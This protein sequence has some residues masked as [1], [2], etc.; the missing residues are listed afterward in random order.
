MNDE[1]RIL[2]TEIRD[3]LRLLRVEQTGKGDD[4]TPLLVTGASSLEYQRERRDLFD[5]L[6]AKRSDQP[7]GATQ[8]S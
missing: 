2:L 6:S 7:A 4:Y 3:E 8:Q 5:E 1:L